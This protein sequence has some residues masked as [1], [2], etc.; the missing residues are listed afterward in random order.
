ML[1]SLGDPTEILFPMTEYLAL[2]ASVG[3]SYDST[4]AEDTDRNSLTTLVGITLQL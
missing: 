1:R 4:P 2:K 3:D